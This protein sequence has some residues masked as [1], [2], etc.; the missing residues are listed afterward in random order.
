MFTKFAAVLGILATIAI[1]AL[2]AENPKPVA[3]KTFSFQKQ[4]ATLAAMT[5]E[6]TKQTGLVIDTSALDGKAVHSFSCDKVSFWQALDQIATVN[7]ARIGSIDRSNRIKLE[8][9]EKTKSIAYNDGAF[10][11]SAIDVARNQ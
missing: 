7:G 10:R 5:S 2:H 9:A 8:L 6:L 4:E 3:P 1:C 11:I